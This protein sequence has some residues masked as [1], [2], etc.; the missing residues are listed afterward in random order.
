MS[1]RV[2][3]AD[4]REKTDR[5]LR[6]MEENLAEIYRRAGAEMEKKADAYFSAFRKADEK[7][8]AQVKAGKLSEDDYKKWRKNKLLYGKRFA[9]FKEKI[10]A[11]LAN[12]NETAL[13]YING[14]LPEVYVINCNGMG[15]GITD[16]V[17]ISIAA[18]RNYY[19]GVSFDLVDADTV[20]YLASKD[21]TLLPRKKLDISKDKRWNMKKVQAEVLQ[22]I[23]QGESIPKIAARMQNVTDMNRDAAV[24]NARTM[25][26]G[27][28]NRGRLDG[29]VRAS[30]NGIILEREWM[31]A[32]DRRVRDLHVLLDGQRRPVDKPFEVEGYVI[33]YP[34]D[35][36]ARPEMVYNCR[37]TTCAVVTGFKNPVTGKTAFVGAVSSYSQEKPGNTE[38]KTRRVSSDR[39]QYEHYKEILG[40]NAPVSLEK[41][42]KLK[43]NSDTWNSFQDYVKSV[44]SGELTSLA[45]F[46][47]YQETSNL[48]DQQLI[49]I[50]TSE[51]VT[52]TGKSKH[53][54]ARMIGSVEQR[55]NGVD[56]SDIQEALESP[57][58]VISRS[59][60]V[61][62]VLE[63]RCSVSMNPQTGNLIQVNPIHTSKQV[64]HENNG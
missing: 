55:R 25:V 4:A 43:Y 48:I 52:I 9:D 40:S 64:K 47:L 31:D 34:G 32:G 23:I 2:T 1:A 39:K 12:V 7:K 36:G 27:A 21:R 14:E 6:K 46:E 3:A 29:M 5:N 38:Q 22:G 13:S 50:V 44:Q 28:E 41:F 10:A 58:A 24:R 60:S 63:G 54:I 56:I 53:F 26:T 16:A 11:E 51:G 37:C 62:Y 33:M 45:D 42:R 49:G 8:R 18:E 15:T 57:S 17:D 61:Q 30:D 20:K 19:A 59:T 35:P